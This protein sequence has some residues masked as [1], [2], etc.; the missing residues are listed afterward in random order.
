MASRRDEL[1]AYTFARKRTVGAFLLPAGGGSDEDAPRPVKAV[2]PSILAGAVVVAGF[3]LW[4]VFKPSAP[5]KWDDGKNVIQGKQSTTRYV[6]LTDPD[7]RT[8]RLHQVLN[9]SSARLV[10][11]VDAKVVVVDDGV[12]DRYPNH[13]PTIGIPYAPDKL[14]SKDN[15]SQ[16]M[17]W[18]VCDRP[19]SDEKRETVNQAVFVAAGQDAAALA[20]K[21][22]MLGPDQLM[23]VQQADDQ[24]V[25]AAPVPGQQAAGG[26]KTYLV[27]AQ[28][29]KHE[30][31]SPQSDDKERRSLITAVFGP[32]AVAQRVKREWL[33]TL[34]TGSPITFPQIDGVADS[35]GPNSTVGLGNAADRR[36]GRLVHYQDRHYVVG[37]DRLYLVTQFQAELIRQNPAYQMLY[38]YDQDKNPRSDGMTPLDHS[39]FDSET[40]LPGTAA[41][42]PLKA[43]APVNNWKDP[44]D[45]RSVVCSTFD[46]VA[47]DGR[48]PKRSVWAGT[49]YPAQYNNGAGAG[50]VTPGH[51]LFYRALDNAAGGSGTDFLITETGLRYAVPA[52]GDGGRGATPAPGGQPGQSG[53]P[54][55]PTPQPGAPNPGAPDQQSGQQ[56][57]QQ[58]GQ[59]PGQQQDETGGNQA[60]LGYQGLQP[61]PVP[62]E[63]S[64]LVPAGPPL[65]AKSAAQP[66][67][68]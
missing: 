50:Y 38:K 32:N 51:G 9:M 27:D 25:S 36:V 24:Q 34:V 16:P 31:G 30:I 45:A 20:A 49:S 40:R 42:W 48:T 68:A 5:L 26:P 59:Q 8:K 29:R 46:G 66:Q 63:W 67:N 43:G 61:L 56:Q 54:K 41:D 37:K 10:L 2:L 12:L 57:G 28:G 65:T 13:G 19:G 4:G 58:A 64:D 47:E 6:V 21:D 11:P 15:A 52:N 14:P 44:Q 62:H 22:R 3:G 7:G 1:N 33:D 17:K 53:A 60:R 23:L 39:Q 35:Q 18:A 55:P